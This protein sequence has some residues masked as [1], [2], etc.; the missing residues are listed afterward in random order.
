MPQRQQTIDVATMTATTPP[1]HFFSVK[2]KWAVITGV[3]VLLIFALFG[4]LLYQSF[5]NLLLSQ[6]KQYA[7]YAVRVATTRVAAN[8][9]ALTAT[10][11]NQ[12]LSEDLVKQKVNTTSDIYSNALFMALTRKNIGV[13]VYSTKGQLLFASRK[14]MH[15]FNRKTPYYTAVKRVAGH[16]VYVKTRPVRSVQTHKLVGYV[17]VTDTLL[18]YDMTTK[19]LV[20]IF[21]IFGLI[22]ALACAFL[23]YALVNILLR[24]IDLINETIRKINDAD[25]NDPFATAR[26]PQLP[27]N[28]ELTQ[29]V[30][31]FNEMLDRMESY[32]E[33]QQQFVEDV[34]HELRTPVAIIKGHLELLN[35]WGKEDPEV[36]DESITASLQEI[37]RMKSLVQE[38]LDL[39]RAGQVEIQFSNEVSDVREV[40][41]QVFHNFEMIHP[42]FNFVLDNDL[43]NPTPAQIYRNHLEQVLIILMDNAV[44]YSTERKEVH[45]TLAKSARNVEIAVQDFGE[46]ISKE[47]LRKIFHRFYRVDKARSRDKGGNGLGLAIAQRLIE[48]YHCT[49]NVESVEGQGSIFRI[50]L[51][52]TSANKTKKAPKASKRAAKRDGASDK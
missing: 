24:P 33:Q 6:E 4:V 14:V 22:V 2:L 1:R 41:L 38:M 32:I 18:D 17:Q 47:N 8:K 10:Q 36:L 46:G 28:D 27:Q 45:L 39:S 30:A 13:S 16:T 19:K 25:E 49:L 44:K 11:V 48:G 20:L 50:T 12:I 52:L 51:P 35:R 7:N 34:S 43:K 21:I 37:T 5:S 9:Q 15:T 23:G 29:L 42:D 26:V 40:G 31:L 3:G